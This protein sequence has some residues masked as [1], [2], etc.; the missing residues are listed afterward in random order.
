MT[1]RRLASTGTTAAAVAARSGLA[2]AVGVSGGAVRGRRGVQT[3]GLLQGREVISHA[4]CGTNAMGMVEI[5]EVHTA[6]PTRYRGRDDGLS[7]L[8]CRGNRETIR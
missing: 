3:K 7:R 2:V 5:R 1:C 8:A 6:C 4:L